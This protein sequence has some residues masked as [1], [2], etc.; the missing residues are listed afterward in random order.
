MSHNQ[1]RIRPRASASAVALLVLFS[2]TASAQP[3]SP[4]GAAQPSRETGLATS[5]PKGDRPAKGNTDSGLLGPVRIGAFGGVG[6]PWP[7]SVEGMVKI[8]GIVGLG[9]EYGV[10][11]QVTVSNVTA[12]LSAID[13]DI[14]VFPM[15]N[16]FF[17]GV[18]VGRQQ[19]DVA[20]NVALPEGLGSLAEQVSVESWFVNPRIGFLW[21]LSWGLTLGM[22]AGV[23]IPVA[24]NVTSTIP[25]EL[26]AGQTV[27][28]VAHA[29]G[30]EVLPTV[31]LLRLG[32]LF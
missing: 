9:L 21:T 8:G 7:V 23:Q 18:A 31:N 2:A 13:A 14:R 15:K 3:S 25:T 10:L 4:D 22:N 11:P 26:I 20:A 12:S 24:S 30:S 29:L 17:V 16:G 5:G 32:F 28:N 27:M 6:F 19:L 1:R